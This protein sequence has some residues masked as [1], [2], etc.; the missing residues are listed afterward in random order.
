LEVGAGIEAVCTDLA[1]RLG[2][3]VK[4]NR[5]EASLWLPE[6]K[7][8]QVMFELG[9]AAKGREVSSLLNRADTPRDFG[10]WATEWSSEA[11]VP[12]V[13]VSIGCVA[14]GA[15]IDRDE[16][17]LARCASMVAAALG[18]SRTKPVFSAAANAL[19]PGPAPGQFG[20]LQEAA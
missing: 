5:F 16:T 8:L 9:T 1:L 18:M 10:S 6:Q 2:A 13:A 15:Y 17:V 7:R 11:V 19:E 3:L 20:P 4:F 12:R 14:S